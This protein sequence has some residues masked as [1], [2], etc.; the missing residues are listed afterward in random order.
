MEGHSRFNLEDTKSR[1]R[2]REKR[3]DKLKENL[4][5]NLSSGNLAIKGLI[6]MG[7]TR[8]RMIQRQPKDHIENYVSH[9]TET[10]NSP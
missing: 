5:K 8:K 2:Q 1:D 3:D 10:R 9:F 6:S 7:S 4:L